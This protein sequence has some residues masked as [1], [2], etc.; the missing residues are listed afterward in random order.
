MHPIDS[1]ETYPGIVPETAF[2][3]F[4]NY[5]K[6]TSLDSFVINP[7][8]Q[9]NEHYIHEHYQQYYKDIKVEGGG[10]NFHFKDG[11]MKL[12]HGHYV[13][14][15]GLNTNPNIS[16]TMAAEIFAEYKHVPKDSIDDFIIELLIKEVLLT[17][18]SRRE[19]IPRLVYRVYLLA[20]H[21]QNDEVG[22]VE[23]HTGEVVATEPRVLDYSATA[24]F[25]TRYNGMKY[26]TTQFYN[27]VYNLCDSTRYSTNGPVIHTWNLN[28]NIYFH[29]AI[30][31]TD[32]N[33]YWSAD[34]L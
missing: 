26:A 8:R 7:Q 1:N 12:A 17:N 21:T 3:F 5:L 28:G 20:N 11:Q 19:I 34:E 6:T 27:G 13:K 9:K 25:E 14:I 30:E 33:N 31:L 22:F 4:K 2:D 24:S 15:E 16:T 32:E 29:N 18:N 23:A 10:Y